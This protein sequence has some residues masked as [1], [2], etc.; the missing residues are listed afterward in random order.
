MGL[1][2]RKSFN[3]GAGFKIN[4]SKSGI[5]YSWGVPGYRVTKTAS[6]KTRTTA[7]IPGSGISYVAE[8]SGQ[9]D[10]K[11]KS[12]TSNPDAYSDIADIESSEISCFQP[13]EYSVLLKKLNIIYKLNRIPLW[14]CVFFL[15]VPSHIIVIL[16]ILGILIR[17]FLLF[18]G[19]VNLDYTLD[20]D[21]A[22][23]YE[24]RIAAWKSLS[25]SNK[26]CHVLQSGKVNN[27]K[28]IGGAE[29]AVNFSDA[30]LIPRLPRF[31]KSNI[32]GI[33]L[34]L[35]K[36]S[37]IFLPDK[38]LIIKNNKI[39]A[40]NYEKL[41]YDIYAFGFIE[42]KNPPKDAEF[43]QNVW[44]YTNKDGSPDKRHQDNRQL[45]VYKYGRIDITSPEGLNVQIVCSN[46]KL[47]EDF[48]NTINL[49]N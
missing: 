20:E 40:I 29:G 15:F 21:M 24:K 11:P 14:L 10:A 31:L 2:V 26:F 19:R 17:I 28:N 22:R 36:E 34:K 7:S 42:A 39:G 23:E 41:K 35:K 38:L 8:S 46:E 1:R 47:V 6:G 25:K 37:L 18:K 12:S 4:L 43:A 49:T 9:K 44:L 45:P 32:K 13:A 48:K 33:T 3:L 27:S 30:K 16:G 5:G